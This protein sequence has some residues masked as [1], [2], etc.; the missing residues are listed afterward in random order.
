MRGSAINIINK[1]LSACSKELTDLCRHGL[2]NT[3]W[4]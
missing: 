3:L 1:P 2:I 4:E